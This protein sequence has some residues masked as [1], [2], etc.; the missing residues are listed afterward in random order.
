MPKRS[1]AISTIFLAV[2]I[3]NAA[4]QVAPPAA[5]NLHGKH[6]MA[7]VP[8][9]DDGIPATG[10]D[11]RLPYYL[12]LGHY[13]DDNVLY[14]AMV[15]TV[16][17]KFNGN[18][19]RL[20]VE[21]LAIDKGKVRQGT[22][23]TFNLRTAGE[24]VM[25]K[26]KARVVDDGKSI[27]VKLPGAGGNVTVSFDEVWPKGSGIFVGNVA[28][29]VTTVPDPP[30]TIFVDANNVDGLKTDGHKLA[31]EIYNSALSTSTVTEEKA[32]FTFKSVHGQGTFYKDL[33][34]ET[35]LEGV[36]WCSVN[37][38]KSLKS[39]SVKISHNVDGGSGYLKYTGTVPNVGNG[40]KP[41]F[42]G[43]TGVTTDHKYYICRARPKGPFNPGYYVDLASQSGS[44]PTEASDVTISTY[45]Y[46]PATNKLYV[47]VGLKSDPPLSLTFNVR[48][49]LGPTG[50]FTVDVE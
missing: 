32:Q 35:S 38:T 2:C 13:P 3:F 25:K 36:G 19:A 29:L 1:A 42:K 28:H 43:K 18:P 23:L 37:P 26:V 17:M 41:K 6:F 47:K 45:Y 11:K 50:Q 10:G 34:F 9:N 30:V 46:D 5:I 20:R 8:V 40:K 24:V 7:L 14:G 15:R 44:I 21:H 27:E 4:F 48:N 31:K 49:L 39:A 12:V 16:L 22:S 33:G